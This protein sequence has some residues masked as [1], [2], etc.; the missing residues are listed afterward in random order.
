MESKNVNQRMLRLL[1]LLIFFSSCATGKLRFG[2]KM[3]QN[4]Q[5]QANY[6]LTPELNRKSAALTSDTNS[7]SNEAIQQRTSENWIDK[8]LEI[9]DLTLTDNT[10][11]AYQHLRSKRQAT[12][13]KN[14][15]DKPRTV[16]N[17]FLIVSAALAAIA[18]IFLLFYFVMR[19]QNPN[20]SPLGC[21]I[22]LSTTALFA[23]L[24][25]IFGITAV[26]FLFI[27]IAALSKA[28]REATRVKEP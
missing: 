6:H 21:F 23:V 17:I 10:L 1:I 14:Q 15:A 24:S 5:E 8:H 28:Y 25:I 13:Q 16:G 2:P 19:N 7:T 27:G 3:E 4:Q 22:T 26:I 11:V 18:L 9:I 12:F 20:G